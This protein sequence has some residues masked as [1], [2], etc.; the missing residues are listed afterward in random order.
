MLKEHRYQ[1][2]VT[3][4]PFSI[5][6]SMFIIEGVYGHR[7]HGLDHGRTK[8]LKGV[9]HDPPNKIKSNAIK[10]KHTKKSQP[11]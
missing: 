8:H 2:N 4:D 11:H 7:R 3:W 6:G 9:L 10:P 1:E 5:V